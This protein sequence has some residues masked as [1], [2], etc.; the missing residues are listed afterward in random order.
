MPDGA[1]KIGS[2]VVGLDEVLAGGFPVHRFHLVVGDPG[3]G[4][5]TLALRFLLEGARRGERVLYVTLSETAE[6]LRA[7][8]RSHGWALDGIA[9]YELVPAEERLRPDQQYTILHPSEVELGETTEAVLS[10]VERTRPVR[11]VFDSLSELRLLARD[12]LVYRRQILSLPRG[13]TADPGGAGACGGPAAPGCAGDPAALVGPA[14]DRAGERRRHDEGRRRAG[15]AARYPRQRDLPGAAGARHD[16]GERGAVGP[17]SWSRPA[18]RRRES[19]SRTRDP[20]SRQRRCHTCSSAS[21][22]VAGSSARAEGT[23]LGLYIARGLV[24]AHGGRITVESE[25]G[26]GSTFSF[27]LPR[28]GSSGADR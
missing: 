12:P 23:G 17:T 11:A 13:R 4:K 10:E 25:P 21:L 24:E 27:T 9:I 19:R 14:A 8:A 22:R 15:R 5:T 16:A 26:R 28:V 7:V 20:A 6:E 18:P 3:T 1:E 2:G